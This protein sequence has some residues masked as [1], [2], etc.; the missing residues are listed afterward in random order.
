M[1]FTQADDHAYL[2]TYGMQHFHTSVKG[3]FCGLN[4][5]Q[6]WSPVCYNFPVECGTTFHWNTYNYTTTSTCA[7]CWIDTRK[8]MNISKFHITYILEKNS[9]LD[10]GFQIVIIKSVN[11]ITWLLSQVRAGHRLARAWFNIHVMMLTLLIIIWNPLSN[12][13]FFF[14][15]IY[16]YIK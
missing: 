6:P 13:E 15:Y 12:R 14:Q 1:Y 2:Y 11:I 9:L 4:V 3:S 5:T 10:S 7:V 16:I 8:P